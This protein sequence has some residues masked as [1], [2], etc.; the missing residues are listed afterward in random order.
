[1]R[2]SL[3]F[4]TTRRAQPDLRRVSSLVAS[5]YSALL[6]T[7]G[8]QREPTLWRH[9]ESPSFAQRL[10]ERP[11][12]R[13]WGCIFFTCSSIEAL[14]CGLTCSCSQSAMNSTRRGG[15]V[16]IRRKPNAM[17]CRTKQ[18]GRCCS[19]QTKASHHD[20]RPRNSSLL[21]L[22]GGLGLIAFIAATASCC[23]R[24]TTQKAISIQSTVV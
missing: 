14:S 1:M 5:D 22:F 23:C 10:V 3:S 15:G 11:R 8:R 16:N 21:S 20:Q 6:P 2:A 9:G 13:C 19:K 4:H 24:S 17:L 18:Q 7:V 12:H